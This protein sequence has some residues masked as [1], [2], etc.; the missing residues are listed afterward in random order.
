MLPS[1]SII[2]SVFTLCSVFLMRIYNLPSSLPPA[3]PD[4]DISC[5]E[6]S[7]YEMQDREVQEIFDRRVVG[8]FRRSK[9][10]SLSGQVQIDV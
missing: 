5:R 8:H 9:K 6:Q 4:G 7:F 10:I 2:I 1:L 3:I